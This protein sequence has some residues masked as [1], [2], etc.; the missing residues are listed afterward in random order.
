MAAEKQDPPLKAVIKRLA[1]ALW[2]ILFVP[3]AILLVRTGE[4][5]PYQHVAEDIAEPLSIVALV[6]ASFYVVFWIIGF[7]H[8]SSAVFSIILSIL[9]IMVWE[10]IAPAI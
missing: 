8:M 5:G 7:Q 9:G 3:P 2:P 4:F 1:G 10:S 6:Y